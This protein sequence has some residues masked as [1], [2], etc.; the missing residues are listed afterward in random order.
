V[1]APGP[2]PFVLL[3]L[4]TSHKWS[5][6]GKRELHR[7]LKKKDDKLKEINFGAAIYCILRFVS[8][9]DG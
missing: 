6:L 8:G 1:Y 3:T 7:F 4:L 2:H 5:I 9:G